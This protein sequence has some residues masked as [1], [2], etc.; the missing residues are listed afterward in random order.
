MGQRQ[1]N[2]INTLKQ[3]GYI[4]TIHRPDFKGLAEHYLNEISSVYKEL[5]GILIEAPVKFGSFDFNND[6]FIFEFDEEQH[7]NRYRAITLKS[8]I[9]NKNDSNINN[10]KDWCNKMEV[11]CLSKASYGKYWSS[12][13]TEK[14]FG[15]PNSK[16]NLS[17]NGSPRWKQRA[18]YDFIKDCYAQFI[19]IPIIR[20]S[21]YD[22]INMNNIG[23]FISDN[24]FQKY[25]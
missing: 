13:S 20:I 16:G 19:G 15:N 1:N 5:G 23:N 9:Y 6:N 2:L 24:L 7:F 22:T 25:D 18:Y 14:Q 11:K 12:I 4:N 17:N 21:V 10:Y 3:L 8:S